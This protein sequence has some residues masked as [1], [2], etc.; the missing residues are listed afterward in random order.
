MKT[1]KAILIL[2]GALFLL[3]TPISSQADTFTFYNITNN[4][5]T[6]L[7][8]QLF[9]DVTDPGN[10]RVSFKFSNNVGFASS[11][12]DI[13]FADGL[14]L[15]TTPAPEITTSG[16]GPNFA[17]P[18]TPPELPG[19]S[20]KWDVVYSAD[21]DEPPPL[22]GIDA[23]G[24]WVTIIFDLASEKSFSDVITDINAGDL[25]IGLHVQAIGPN[26]EGSDSYVVRVPEPGILI[27]L[28]LA[29]SAI[30]VASWRMRKI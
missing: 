1:T 7:S 23:A 24:E 2:A 25:L 18:A 26:G 11:I 28:G 27:L 9:V 6:D 19:S 3:F 16:N 21:S 4:V 8:G 17:S 12:T 5:N 29:M 10:N 30:G 20:N 22:N 15:V 14:V 13:Y